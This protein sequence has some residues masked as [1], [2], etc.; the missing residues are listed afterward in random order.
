VLVEQRMEGEAQRSWNNA[1]PVWSPDGEQIAFLSDR[2]GRWEVWVMDANGSNQRPLFS[3]QVN[4]QLNLQF[5]GVDER[6]LS[7][8]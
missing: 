8:R 1:A 4:D 5:N 2:S 6:A 7:W 3:D